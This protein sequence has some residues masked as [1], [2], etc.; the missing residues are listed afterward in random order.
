MIFAFIWKCG[1]SSNALTYPANVFRLSI[2]QSGHWFASL[3]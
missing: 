2:W 1:G 3:Y